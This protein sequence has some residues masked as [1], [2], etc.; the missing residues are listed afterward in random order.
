MTSQW[1]GRRSCRRE[2]TALPASLCCME[3]EGQVAS[4]A[5]QGD[6]VSHFFS[7]SRVNKKCNL[8]IHTGAKRSTLGAFD[9]RC[10][11]RTV[12][13]SSRLRRK[14]CSPRARIRIR[15]AGARVASLGIDRRDVR[16]RRARDG[17]FVGV[18]FVS[19]VRPRV[20]TRVEVV[21]RACSSRDRSTCRHPRGP[22]GGG[23]VRASPKVARG[24]WRARRRVL[25]RKSLRR[26]RRRGEARGGQG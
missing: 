23:L 4:A 26:R 21:V 3:C 6:T 24:G 2:A 16:P 20:A 1:T 5:S 12:R 15:V 10:T 11:V 19:F 17:V 8:Y 22:D 9:M 25:V 14:S 7:F 13:S 18:A